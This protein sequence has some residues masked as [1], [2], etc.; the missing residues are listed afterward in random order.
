MSRVN[1]KQCI[2]ACDPMLLGC[3]H[4]DLFAV[5]PA[6]GVLRFVVDSIFAD[7]NVTMTI[8]GSYGHQELLLEV[9]D[10]GFQQASTYRV[11]Q[12]FSDLSYSKCFAVEC[13][14]HACDHAVALAVP[15]AG[16]PLLTLENP[17]APWEQAKSYVVKM[18]NPG[19]CGASGS[20]QTSA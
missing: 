20:V 11:A 5:I 13:A 4:T 18:P 3:R 6:P 7:S 2:V 9:S 17:C 1:Q 10:R 12:W 16:N 15:R 19:E 14:A 8:F